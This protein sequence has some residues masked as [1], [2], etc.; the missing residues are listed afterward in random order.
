MAASFLPRLPIQEVF[1][2]DH[3]NNV[4]QLTNFR[5]SIR[6][7]NAERRRTRRGLIASAGPV[8]SNP[9]ENCQIFSIDRI[10]AICAS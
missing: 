10:G 5:V 7:P 2:L 4:L 8:G 1:V 9:T 6:G 3:D